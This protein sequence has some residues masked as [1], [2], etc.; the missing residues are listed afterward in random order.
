VSRSRS[1]LLFAAAILVTGVLSGIVG[2][3][4]TV[5]ER[6]IQHLVYGYSHGPLL[7]GVLAAPP[8]RRLLGPALGCT[9]AG[10]GW[11]LLRRKT[12]VPGL[13]HSIREN[14]PLSTVPMSLDA[15]LQVV[16]VGSGASLGREQAPRML[17]AVGADLLIRAGSLPAAHRRILLAGAA[18]AG[19]A[20]VYNVPAAGALFTAGIVLRSWRPIVVLVAVA[21]SSI[22]TVTAWPVSH[23]APT[24][25]WPRTDFTSTSVLIAVAVMPVAALVGVGFNWLVRRARP[26]APP[27]A[28]TL[29]PAIGLAGLLTGTAS[30][31]LPQLPG[32]GKSIVL[33]SL[34]GGVPML[35]FAVAVVLKPALTA[36]FIRGGAVGGM[37]TPALST[38]TATGAFIAMAINQCGGHA[39]IATS[40]L[41]GGAAV[42]AVTQNAPI[43]A[44]VFTAELTHPPLG[45]SGLLMLVALGAHAM[46]WACRRAP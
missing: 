36:L 28:W 17:A 20:A 10:L 31:W 14:R 33:G 13:N 30:L 27:T 2:A 3:S 6:A 15:L 1:H 16:A 12:T 46:R 43:F 26:P 40:A 4:I 41:M 44:A 7:L 39:S 19:L 11:W 8:E 37:I 34:A 45:V 9:L 25:L 21:T 32:N 18:G 42:L 23:G 38:G 24:F 5:V 22:A 29:V 35:A